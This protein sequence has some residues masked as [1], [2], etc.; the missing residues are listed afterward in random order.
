MEYWDIYDKDGNFTGRK[1]G[2]YE[3]WSKDEY[4]LATE[5]WVINSKKQILIQKRSDKCEILPGM[6]ALTTGRVVSGE[7]TRQ[8]CIRELREELGINASEDECKLVKSYLKNRL[9]MIWDIY[10]IRKDIELNNIT[11]QKDEVSRAK[12]VDTDEFRQMLKEGIMCEYS[13]IYELLEI[14]DKLD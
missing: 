11:L 5:V 10:F 1:K 2:K 8:G 7:T 4:H 12:F 6:W 3:K 14:V 13:E 9:G